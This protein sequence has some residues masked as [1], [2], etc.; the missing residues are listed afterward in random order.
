MAELRQLIKDFTVQIGQKI[1]TLA[2][3]G[4]IKDVTHTSGRKSLEF[5]HRSSGK[6]I[7]FEHRSSRKS[8]EFEHLSSRKSFEFEHRLSRDSFEVDHRVSRERFDMDRAREMES[9]QKLAGQ[10]IEIQKFCAKPRAFLGKLR[11]R[12]LLKRRI[13]II[14]MII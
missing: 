12:V 8:F 9:L 14:S 1:K 4:L 3:V 7:E 11:R 5:Q 13:L 10:Q 2:E 6:L